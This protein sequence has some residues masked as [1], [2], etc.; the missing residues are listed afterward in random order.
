[1]TAKRRKVMSEKKHE[2]LSNLGTTKSVVPEALKRSVSAA[3]A[4]PLTSMERVTEEVEES[5]ALHAAFEREVC[6]AVQQRLE[7]DP[8]YNPDIYPNA[9]K[10]FKGNK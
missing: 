5:T 9:E 1:M 2:K 8:D 6:S 4:E 3:G 10:F 7:H